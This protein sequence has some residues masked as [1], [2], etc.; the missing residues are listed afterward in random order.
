MAAIIILAYAQTSLYNEYSS[1]TIMNR[2]NINHI[3]QFLFQSGVL[4]QKQGLLQC[5]YVTKEPQSYFVNNK[6][7]IYNIPVRQ[8]VNYLKALSMRR[9]TD[10]SNYIPRQFFNKVET[11]ILMEVDADYIYFPLESSVSRKSYD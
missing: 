9:I 4:E 11:N 7:F 6:F 8:K 1:K 3:P 5:N 2:L 10:N